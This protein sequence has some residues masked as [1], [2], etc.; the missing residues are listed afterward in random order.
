MTSDLQSDVEETRHVNFQYENI[1]T[2]SEDSDN[3]SQSLLPQAPTIH[4]SSLTQPSTSHTMLNSTPHAHNRFQHTPPQAQS[5]ILQHTTQAPQSLSTQFLEQPLTHPQTHMS[6]T[7]SL[8]QNLE[9]I[10]HTHSCS[11]STL[12]LKILKQIEV[13][14][15]TVTQLWQ[16]SN[17]PPSS[18]PSPVA[19]L[20]P[21]FPVSLPVS[22][23]EDL[24]A[25]EDFLKEKSNFGQTVIGFWFFFL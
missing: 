20:P 24:A 16:Q 6:N 8:I 12:N 4:R 14:L 11:C 7:T 15:K 23:L 3:D 21:N 22:T 25:V 18:K 5:V 19:C 9:N 1:D 17:Q 2:D 10:Q 13:H